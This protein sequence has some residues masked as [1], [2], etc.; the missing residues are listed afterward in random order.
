M[1]QWSIYLPSITETLQNEVKKY[2][3]RIAVKQKKNIYNHIK[4]DRDRYRDAYS[5]GVYEIPLIHNN[6]NRVY[7]GITMRRISKR[8]TEH[9]ADIKYNRDKTSLSKLAAK[10]E[11]TVNFQN[12]KKI[13]H[14]NNQK[15]A[16]LR[17]S[18]E[19]KTNKS[20]INEHG[21]ITIP[22]AWNRLISEITRN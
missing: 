14:Y 19:I 5:E 7:I 4:N 13:D 3:G 2:G 16:L 6:E 11:I 21:S 17:E 1:G 12:T 20:S 22:R 18:I 15:Y 10:E 8:I 9:I